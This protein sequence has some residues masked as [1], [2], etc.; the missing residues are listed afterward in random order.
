MNATAEETTGTA[1]APVANPFAAPI[2]AA[3]TGAAAHAL[4]QREVAEVQAM[5]VIAKAHPRDPRA[6]VDRI[7]M[8]C[9]RES[10]AESALYS[11]SRGGQEITG[12]SI[13]LAEELARSW[14]NMLCG[15]TEL[16]RLESRSECLTYAW[17]LESNF[18]D[19]KRFTIRHWRDTKKGGYAVTEERDLY[20]MIANFGARRKR[21]CILAVIPPDVTEAAIRQC[22][23]TLKTK[24]TVTPERVKAMVEAFATLGV[25]REHI[26]KRIQRHLDSITPAQMVQM[27]KIL[28]SL[29][30]GMSE[31]GA[32]FEMPEGAE[33]AQPP[34]TATEGVRNKLAARRGG[35]APAAKESDAIPHYNAEQARAA[36]L[37]AKTV[38]ELDRSWAS[39]KKDFSD[40]KRDLPIELESSYTE[41]RETMGED[42]A[43]RS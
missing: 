24:G 39:I 17:D 32:W 19:E 30:D 25:M 9:A 15:V 16:A 6:S 29:K 36:L 8:A 20:E 38:A 12:P 41:L 37:S 14:G 5:M 42:E 10:L 43:R 2:V 23:I 7:L 13:R 22:E 26:E 34:T 18:R 28:N 31:V 11:Y 40:T 27:G 1:V 21:A 33:G 4:V 35:A 3:P